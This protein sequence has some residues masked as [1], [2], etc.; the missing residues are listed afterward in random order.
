M[1]ASLCPLR[2]QAGTSYSIMSIGSRKDCD[3]Y[4][5]ECPCKVPPGI[6]MPTPTPEIRMPTPSATSFPKD[7]VRD[8]LENQRK[9]RKIV[10]SRFSY[11]RSLL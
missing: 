2:T 4:L 6:R 1:A 7:E 8:Y 11:H 3:E 10:K 9:S 5:Q